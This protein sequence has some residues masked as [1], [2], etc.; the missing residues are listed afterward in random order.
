VRVAPG[1]AVFVQLKRAIAN[2]ET[3]IAPEV[4][5]GL[6]LVP[7][8]P[9]GFR[10]RVVGTDLRF[11]VWDAA[12]TE[13]ETWQAQAEDTTPALQAAGGVGFRTFTG[14]PVPNGPV[15][16]SLDALEIRLP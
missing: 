3:A 12:G 9:L 7:G 11:R 8:A 2:A 1:G 16:A 14:A 13:P 4:A 5:T 10:L 15:V 6:T